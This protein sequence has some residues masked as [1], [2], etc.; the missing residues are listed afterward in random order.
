VLPPASSG[1]NAFAQSIDRAKVQR[2]PTHPVPDAI[3]RDAQEWAGRVPWPA[4]RSSNAGD[5]T[6][7]LVTDLRAT[8][9]LFG[10][11]QP[12]VPLAPDP[13][14]PMVRPWGADAG[15][16]VELQ[17]LPVSVVLDLGNTVF[18][19]N[20]ETL[21]AYTDATG[22][23]PITNVT[24]GVP[25]DLQI[26]MSGPGAILWVMT[27]V[28]FGQY[29]TASD[30]TIRLEIQDGFF[31]VLAQANEANLYA[32]TILQVQTKWAWI[33]IAG[34]LSDIVTALQGSYTSEPLMF[35]PCFG[36]GG[37]GNGEDLVSQFIDGMV[38]NSVAAY[39]LKNTKVSGEHSDIF[40]PGGDSTDMIMSRGVLSH[41]YGHFILCSIL[42]NEFRLHDAYLQ[43]IM[44][45]INN[46]DPTTNLPPAT[47]DAA[48]IN[49][50]IA[51]FFAAQ[52]AGGT[53]YFAL[54]GSTNG[55]RG[56]MNYCCT[57][58]GCGYCMET[59]CTEQNAQFSA[60]DPCENDV[61]FLDQVAF[62]ATL[63][64]DIFDPTPVPEYY[65][66]R[67]WQKNPNSTYLVYDQQSYLIS[68]ANLYDE[69]L[70][71]DASS[72]GSIIGMAL[73]TTPVTES[74]FLQG[75]TGALGHYNWCDICRLF[76][77]HEGPLYTQADSAL[78]AY[79]ET[80]V[81]SGQWTWMSEWPD[82]TNPS[83][84]NYDNCLPGQTETVNAPCP[85]VLTC[86]WYGTWPSYT[87][88]QA[89]YQVLCEDCDG[90][91]YYNQDS[92]LTT[93]CPGSPVPPGTCPNPSI[94]W[95]PIT[96]LAVPAGTCV[97]PSTVY[98]PATGFLGGELGSC[99][100]N[101]NI[102]PYAPPVC[103]EKMDCG[104][105][106]GCYSP[107][108]YDCSP[109][110]G[111]WDPSNFIYSQ[112]GTEPSSCGPLNDMNVCNVGTN[113]HTQT[114]LPS[115][116]SWFANDPAMQHGGSDSCNIGNRSGDTGFITGSAYEVPYTEGN[117]CLMQ[118][119]PYL[120]DIESNRY[121]VGFSI[122]AVNTQDVR[123]EVWKTVGSTQTELYEQRVTLQNLDPCFTIN[124]LELAPCENLEFKMQWIHNAIS[125]HTVYLYE[126]F[127]S[128]DDG[129]VGC[130]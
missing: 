36:L 48:W 4:P 29:T 81:T 17:G 91:G 97:S 113:C 61:V 14:L 108:G 110:W 127:V 19:S 100:D 41:E 64:Y 10:G 60:A 65:S 34:G 102:H 6:V 101:P 22:V 45:R 24:S 67:A 72:T 52:L 76:A 47:A 55:T 94:G 57:A 20:T 121:K 111:C 40:V 12:G 23:A 21:S 73:T 119:G 70:T 43:M 123:F 13:S 90:D 63:L 3:A 89:P 31:N 50:A 71:Y 68:D 33:N 74:S 96:P 95:L 66:G 92:C 105:S 115:V 124:D 42:Y 106:C 30:T 99:D 107:N 117:D 122:H 62:T 46:V 88:N 18:G 5:P 112:A 125:N 51:D 35:S 78:N 75:L 58:V 103:G 98:S 128:P 83:S 87:S 69:K 130:W 38:S 2:P 16:A 54:P 79:C 114:L 82:P 11:V 85:L 44:E 7:T 56:P 39:Y 116:F 1:S 80:Q 26:T 49:E 118:W 9:P 77:I 15:S 129:G 109:S 84:C 27:Y 8:D 93:Y 37:L 53:N 120:N 86:Q 59:N 28:D 32:N 25:F 104:V 126:T